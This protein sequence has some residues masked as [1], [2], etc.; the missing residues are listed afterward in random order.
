MNPEIRLLVH[1]INDDL[2]KGGLFGPFTYHYNKQSPISE[3]RLHDITIIAV[4]ENT[5]EK[6]VLDRLTKEIEK[7]MNF[8]TKLSEVV[9]DLRK[10]VE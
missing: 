10:I 1:R 7:E 9:Q 2:H 6:E 4:K 5:T 3:I 8:Y